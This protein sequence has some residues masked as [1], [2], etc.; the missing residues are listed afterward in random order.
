MADKVT[1]AEFEKRLADG[2]YDTLTGA[3]RGIGKMAGWS[4][5]ERAAANEK[6]DAYFSKG[7]KKVAPKAKAAPK[8]AKTKA[9]KA[10]KVA[11]APKA[12]KAAPQR[13]AR[14][15]RKAAVAA[16]ASQLELPLSTEI[17]KAQASIE[18]SKALGEILNNAVRT[19]ELGATEADLRK[20]AAAASRDL[21]D[22]IHSLLGTAES[23][24]QVKEPAGDNGSSKVDTAVADAAL[25][26]AANAAKN[27]VAKGPPV[28]PPLMGR[29]G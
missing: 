20:V 17:S 16:P 28:I 8:K 27:T 22:S 29:Q 21:V 19:K 6:A 10:P 26:A 12:A 25:T 18:R 2:R 11:K 23:V 14:G 13:A 24:R 1:M 4:D 3:R 9:P 7:G 5:K 15:S